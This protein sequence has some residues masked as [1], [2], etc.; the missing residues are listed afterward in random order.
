MQDGPDVSEVVL[1]APQRP[2]AEPGAGGDESDG[3]LQEPLVLRPGRRRASRV[4]RRAL[5]AGTADRGG[6]GHGE[7]RSNRAQ[8]SR[9]RT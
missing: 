6:G 9:V 1:P 4:Q 7:V 2:L 5:Q 8:E 3:P